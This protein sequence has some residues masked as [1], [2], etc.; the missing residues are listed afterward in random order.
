MKHYMKKLVILMLALLPITAH[1]DEGMWTIYNLP[2]AA[3]EIMKQEGFQ[4]SYND[5]YYGDHALK[6]AV[7]NFSGYCSGVVVSPNGLVFTNHHCGFEAIRSHST[8]E[9]DYMLNG[10]YAK[11]YEEELPNKNMFVSFMVNQ[12]DVTKRLST[13]G[14]NGMTTEQ[15]E[16][17][18]D[19]LQNAMTKDIK[20]K[21]STLYVSIDAFYEGNKYYAT[22]YQMF[23]DLRLVF[24]VPKSMGKFGG[25]TDNWM[26]PRQTCDFSVF[27]IYADPRTNGPAE[28]NEENVPYHPKRWAQVSMQGYKEGD[29]A[30][31]IGYPGSTNRYLSSYGIKEMRDADNA[32][33]A[34]VRGVKQDIM[35]RHMRADEAVR[36]K[37][38]SKY[39]SSSNYWKNSI[40]MNKCID[41]IGIIN[42]KKQFED[43]I[44]A[45][46]DSTGFL[47]DSLDFAKLKKLY[48]ERFEDRRA[49]MNWVKT[50]NRTNEFTTRAQRLSRGMEVK[51][52]ENK[53]KKQYVEFK[54]N[55]DE[56]DEALDKEVF[57]A[58]LKN[59]KEHVSEKYLPAFYSTISKKFGND[60]TKYVDYLYKK[61][62]IMK[63][64]KKL[65]INKKS[66]LKDPGVKYGL[67]LLE[68]MSS[69]REGL[70]ATYDSIDTQERYLCAAKL[71]MEQD[72]PH[73]SDANFTMRLSYGQVG[74]FELAGNPSGY[75]TTA[76]SIVDK[77][78]K[79]DQNVE[80][81]AEPIMHELM[82]AKNF[83]PYTD[84]TTGEMQLCFLTNNDIT[85]GNSGSP[86]F[87]GKGELIG[88]AFDGNW[89]SL[90]SD[91]NFDKRLARCIGVDIRFVL[92]LMDKWGHADRLLKEIDAK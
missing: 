23:P 63:K 31:T 92:Y 26:W 55:S 88:L 69:I 61:S 79:A 3:F 53:P 86:I 73:Y 89:D 70:L 28:Y 82:S 45:W 66:Y 54:D 35:I 62:M 14:F 52:P 71:R 30:M 85:G 36:I 32:T 91:I 4:M 87:G 41:S 81:Y 33:R 39:A 77:M 51:G 24:T 18:I 20:E 17:L 16:A 42:Q 15:Q 43:R 83:G 68:N 59:Y 76:Q 65:Y 21:D 34:Q 25:E 5:L 19:S 1:A 72:L 75:F 12:E 84:K 50:F 80:Y 46:Q 47:K 90:S 11:T 40:G 60:Y 44:Q 48:E 2:P 78:K 37:Y 57:A 64:G 8:V 6:N 67:D 74:G 56:W 13:L 22:T 58:L 9:H 10:F 7:V 27:R 49:F 38:D 29:Y